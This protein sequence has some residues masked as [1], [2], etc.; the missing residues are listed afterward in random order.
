MV[1]KRGGS[2]R[3]PTGCPIHEFSKYARS[4]SSS[5]RNEVVRDSNVATK[6]ETGTNARAANFF[7]RNLK[8]S[9]Y[10]YLGINHR[11]FTPFQCRVFAEVV[12]KLM[13]LQPAEIMMRKLQE[14]VGQW[15]SLVFVGVNELRELV[16]RE[17]EVVVR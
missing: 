10:L 3:P 11:S 8:A 7:N 15:T 16:A 12:R 6:S 17:E 4:R 2:R 1:R 14:Q 13:E 9:S 5:L